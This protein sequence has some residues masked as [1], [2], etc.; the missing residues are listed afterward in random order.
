L[1]SL[2]AREHFLYG[3]VS[4]NQKEEALHH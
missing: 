4:E 1:M 3:F 2:I